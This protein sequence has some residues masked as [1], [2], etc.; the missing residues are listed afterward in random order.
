ML[1]I[2]IAI[3]IGTLVGLYVGD[4]IVKAAYRSGRR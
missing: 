3:I 4:L 2:L 1:T